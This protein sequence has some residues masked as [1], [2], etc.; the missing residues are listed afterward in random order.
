[1]PM[2]FT[3]HTGFS[4]GSHVPPSAVAQHVYLSVYIPALFSE[5]ERMGCDTDQMDDFF[6]GLSDAVDFLR[7]RRDPEFLEDFKAILARMEGEG[8]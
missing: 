7:P 2:S 3:Y 5:L 6:R 8:C 1:M 4:V